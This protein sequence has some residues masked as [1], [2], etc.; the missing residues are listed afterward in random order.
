MQALDHQRLLFVVYFSILVTSGEQLC[1]RSPAQ[2]RQSSCFIR[3]PCTNFQNMHRIVHRF[4]CSQD[5]YISR[6]SRAEVLRQ[7]AKA[8]VKKDC[9]RVFSGIQP[10]GHVHVGNWLAVMRFWQQDQVQQNNFV[11]IAD[12]HAATGL[13]STPSLG[14]A[15][16]TFQVWL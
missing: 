1:L 5:D 10:S 15:E 16:R 2:W 4:T 3:G 9:V 13:C 8:V 6:M 12:L 7:N 14:L 11:C